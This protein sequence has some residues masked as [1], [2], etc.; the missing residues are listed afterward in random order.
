MLTSLRNV[1][2]RIISH[3]DFTFDSL[4]DFGCGNKPYKP[5]FQNKCHT[6]VGVDIEGNPDADLIIENGRL[7]VENDSFD[8]VL[9]TQVLEYV[10]DPVLYLNEACRV[11]K[12]D[13]TL[14]LSTHGLWQ[15]H[16][17]PTDYWRWTIDGLKKLLR[18]QDL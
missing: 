4:L 3:P 17:D 10:E 14:I 16:P 18:K 1:L 8:C 11:L 7:P 5:L 13:G 2:Q 12:S 6:Y 9:S 15:Y